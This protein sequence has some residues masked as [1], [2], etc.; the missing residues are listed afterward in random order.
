[1]IR[2]IAAYLIAVATL[3][4]P[5][6]ASPDMAELWGKE[7]ASLEKQ[8]ADLIANIDMGGAHQ[9]PDSYVIDVSRF[10][11][12]AHGLAIWNDTSGG[13]KDLGCIF[14]GMATESEDQTMD[15]LD[16]EDNLTARD[17][18]KRLE[19]MFSDAQLIARAAA[20]QSPMPTL[21]RQPA[22]EACPMEMEATRRALQ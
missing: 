19:S 7:A 16:V 18:L 11:R 22:N 20:A 6:K 21:S 1:M 5:A 14:R 9:M 10:G 17:H 13:A 12:M 2:L 4:T 15:L 3:V 8:T